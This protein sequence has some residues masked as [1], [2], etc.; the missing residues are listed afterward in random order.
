MKTVREVMTTD[1]VWINPSA[2]VKT[3]V[4]LMKGHNIG[5]LPVIHTENAVVGLLTRQDVLGEDGDTSVLDLMQKDYTIVDPEAT[6]YDAADMLQQ[7]HTS[8]LLVL[9]EDK[10]IGILSLCD[11]IPELGKTFDPLTELPW[12]DSFREW[13]MHAL[14]RGM[15]ISVMLFDLNGFGMFNKKHSHLVGDNVIKEVAQV[16]RETIDSDQ[17]FAC[18]Y[19]GDEFGVVSIRHADDANALA[20]VIQQKVSAIRI[21]D[22]PDPVTISFGMFGGRRTKEREDIHYAATIDDLITQ[23]SKNCIA[24]KPH[25]APAQ[26]PAAAPEAAPQAAPAAA[27]AAAAPARAPR[28]KIQTVSFAT[29]AEETTVGVTLTRGG[30]EYKGGVVGCVAGVKNVLRLVAEC[31]AQA[32][33]SSLESGYGLAVDDVFARSLGEDD[34]IVTVVTSFVTPKWTTRHV[35][36]AVVVRSDRYRAAVAALLAAINRQLEVAPQAEPQEAFP[37]PPAPSEPSPSEPRPSQDKPQEE[38]AE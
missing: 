34:E 7:T 20:E 1:V 31:T 4:I 5:A 21:K 19:G 10:L 37:E 6:V 30:H 24:N 9:E 28:L 8:H 36:S 38:S 2:R 29:T 15:E 25:R 23:A 14:K 35:G 17:D 26:A 22:V 13:A 32:V 16:F 18:R 12:S 33:R 27:P 11:L 3:A